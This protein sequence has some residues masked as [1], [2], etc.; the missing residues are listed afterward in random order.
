MLQLSPSGVTF[1]HDAE[2][3]RLTSYPDSKGV[4]TIGW[5]TTRIDGKPVRPGMT[6]T[7]EQALAWANADCR[8]ALDAIEASVRVPLTQNQIDALCSFAYNVGIGGFKSSSLLRAINSRQPIAEDLFTRWNKI[9]DPK[10]GQL[11]VLNGLTNRRKREYK[12]FITP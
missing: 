3:L 11:V 1:L 4:W 6:C 9:R 2:E 5:G 12:L 10:T 7:E 8:E